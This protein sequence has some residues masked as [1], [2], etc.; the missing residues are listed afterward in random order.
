M[1]GE[2]AAETFEYPG[3]NAKS[4]VWR[5]FAFYKSK[6]G[7]ATKENLDMSKAICRVCQKEYANE[8]W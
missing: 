1:A 6:E 8:G 7:S 4:M 3:R 2:S 5:Y